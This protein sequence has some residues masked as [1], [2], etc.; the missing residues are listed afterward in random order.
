MYKSVIMTGAA[1]LFI[2]A[3]LAPPAIAKE[4]SKTAVLKACKHMG[5]MC[6]YDS[7]TGVGCTGA[8]PSFEG[9]CFSCG[10][11]TCHQDKE[12]GQPSKG[13]NV[14]NLFYQA[15]SKTP[16]KGKSRSF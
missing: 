7:N 9:V 6:T 15:G 4:V 11:K 10:K 12:T 1:S 5:S 14:G 16:S 13:N 8:T 2:A 3:A